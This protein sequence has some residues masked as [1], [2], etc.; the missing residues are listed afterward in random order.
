MADADAAGLKG[1]ASWPITVSY[2]RDQDARRDTPDYQISFD[3]YENGVATGLLLDYEEFV[4]GGD[5]AKLEFLDA[6]PCD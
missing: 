6:T 2:F 1:L 4:L 5:L 3:L